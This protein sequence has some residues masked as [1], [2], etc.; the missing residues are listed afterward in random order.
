MLSVIF[1]LQSKMLGQ[2]DEHFPCDLSNVVFCQRIKNKMDIS[3]NFPDLQTLWFVFRA[4]WW[5]VQ[6]ITGHPKI[7]QNI[8]NIYMPQ[9]FL[10]FLASTFLFYFWLPFTSYLGIKKILII[11]LP[12][13]LSESFSY[14]QLLTYILHIT[15]LVSH[16]FCKTKTHT[17]RYING[18]R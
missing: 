15:Y 14:S 1:Y 16:I 10:W 12:S 17:D 8:S 4:P 5:H 2:I 11:K 3:I 13:N 7:W 9:F 18:H 6:Q